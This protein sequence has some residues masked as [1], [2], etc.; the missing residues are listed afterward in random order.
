MA[1]RV[2]A[3][4]MPSDPFLR[5]QREPAEYREFAFS[6]AD[7]E[8]VRALIRQYAGIALS[9]AK[10]EMV[11]GRLSRRLRASGDRTFAQ[12]LAR[13][14][15]SRA[16]RE[17]FVNALTT[18]LTSFFREAHHFDMLA[19]QLRRISER[20]T[21]RIWC[22]AAS[23][24]EE[25]YSLA[26]TAC[27]TFDTLTP[28]VQ[29]IASDIDTA[30]LAQAAAG[31]F[32]ADSLDRLSVDRRERFFS[33]AGAAE[34][35]AMMVRP[36]LH[37]LVSFRQINL[38]DPVWPVQG[39]LDAIFCRNVMIY[40]D[41]T[42]Q[43]GILKRFAPLLRADGQLFAGHSESFPQAADILRARGRTVYVRLDSPLR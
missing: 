4:L 33:S 5:E 43:H 23:T 40:F 25:P 39:G 13:L 34:R 31:V 14:E 21:A 18:N 42:T 22:C 17:M 1:V 15:R 26:M 32:R 9:P 3:A 8:R 7:F 27:E 19:E 2:V 24:G 35:G 28:P 20:R 11:Y 12:Y 16:E 41:R 10:Y 36:E 30:V 38:L 6:D 29:I 37:R